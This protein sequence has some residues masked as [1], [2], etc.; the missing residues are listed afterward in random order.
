MYLPRER[1]SFIASLQTNI[2]IELLKKSNIIVDDW[3][4]CSESGEINTAVS[5]DVLEKEDIHG[6]I[7]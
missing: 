7:G 5:E 2:I 1:G 3:E 4:Q 6:E